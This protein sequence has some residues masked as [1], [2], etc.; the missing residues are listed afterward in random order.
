MASPRN[1]RYSRIM[2]CDAHGSGSNSEGPVLSASRSECSAL[3][4]VDTLARLRTWA[5]GKLRLKKNRTPHLY[6]GSL[7]RSDP[8]AASFSAAGCVVRPPGIL[9]RMISPV[10]EVLHAML[11]ADL[12]NGLFGV[13]PMSHAEKPKAPNN[14]PPP[15]PHATLW[16]TPILPQPTAAR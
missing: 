9:Y 4:M 14:P 11:F 3:L 12:Q 7:A 10:A 6:Q 1:S 15:P 8:L 5:Q 16:S 13:P 2:E